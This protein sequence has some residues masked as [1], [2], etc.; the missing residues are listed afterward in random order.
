[1]PKSIDPHRDRLNAA[2]DHIN[3]KWGCGIIGTSIAGLAETHRWSMRWDL[4][5]PRYTTCWAELP[6]AVAM[7]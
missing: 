1:M 6:V 2:V 3:T 4:F 7:A 5:S